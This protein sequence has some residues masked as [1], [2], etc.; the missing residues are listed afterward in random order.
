MKKEIPKMGSK[1]II[2]IPTIN[3]IYLYR[4]EVKDPNILIDDLNNISK[5]VDNINKFLKIY[6][7]LKF[8]R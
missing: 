6:Y 8:T 5:F 4:N 7:C 3:D 1:K 2:I